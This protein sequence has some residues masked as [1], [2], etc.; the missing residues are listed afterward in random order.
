MAAV[1]AHRRA[2]IAVAYSSRRQNALIFN[3]QRT[4]FY[5]SGYICPFRF[6]T[7]RYPVFLSFV[8]CY[9]FF[10]NCCSAQDVKPWEGFGIEVNEFE[11]KVL[12]H[13]AKFELPLPKLTTGTDINLQ[14]KTYG[15]KDWQQRR[16]VS[17]SW[18]GFYLY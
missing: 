12:K 10:A 16:R 14:W 9:L 1:A 5:K 11:G 3:K 13:E 6:Y 4:G 17:C 15:R 2:G 18:P 8:F 7:M